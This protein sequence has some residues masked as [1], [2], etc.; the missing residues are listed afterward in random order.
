MNKERHLNAPGKGEFLYDYKHDILTFKIR[1]R[2][3]KMSV[4]LQNFAIDIDTENFV[5]GIRIFDPLT[6]K[7][8]ASINLDDGGGVEI[9]FSND[10]TKAYVSQMET[11]R[12]FEIDTNT[13]KVISIKSLKVFMPR[14]AFAT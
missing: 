4:E 9:I 8:L 1:D 13:K 14:T 2:D 3:Y 12:I 11:A 7:K 10:N 5:T 6:G